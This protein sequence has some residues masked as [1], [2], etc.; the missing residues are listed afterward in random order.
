M[1]EDGERQWAIQHKVQQDV[2]EMSSHKDRATQV[3]NNE[4]KI[5]QHEKNKANMALRRN[6][7]IITTLVVPG[8]S[9]V[10]Q[11]L[12]ITEGVLKTAVL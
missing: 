6:S 9:W 10:F 4:N 11:G 8:C 1:E 12:Q 5:K 2:E 7:C 3:E